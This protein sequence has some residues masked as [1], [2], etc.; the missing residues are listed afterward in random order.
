MELLVVF[1]NKVWFSLQEDSP[2]KNF[3]HFKN[4]MFPMVQPVHSHT[5]YF[6]HNKLWRANVVKGA[7]NKNNLLPNHGR[8]P[9]FFQNIFTLKSQKRMFSET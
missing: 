9:N 1:R 3:S 4:T 5:E 7:K 8:F 2:G 6:N